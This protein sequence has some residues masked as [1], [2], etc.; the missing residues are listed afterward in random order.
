MATRL[1]EQRLQLQLEQLERLEQLGQLE[2]KS[3]QKSEESDELRGGGG[4]GADKA[5]AA[6][7]TVIIGSRAFDAED[8]VAAT[9]LF[10]ELMDEAGRGGRGRGRGGGRGGAVVSTTQSDLSAPPPPALRTLRVLRPALFQLQRT[11]EGCKERVRVLERCLLEKDLL[12]Q[13]TTTAAT[14]TDADVITSVT[15]AADVI[16]SVPRGVSRHCAAIGANAR[17]GGSDATEWSQ[18]PQQ[19]LDLLQVRDFSFRERE[20]TEREKERE[21]EKEIGGVVVV[22]NIF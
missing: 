22:T 6:G 13:R 5:A 11:A 19:Q 4:G 3:E 12:L 15:R 10:Q 18:L 9:A 17:S 1:S 2:Q 20:K 21:R 14:T 8:T 7:H 16:T